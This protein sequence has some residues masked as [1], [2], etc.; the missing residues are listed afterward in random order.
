M[1]A[2]SKSAIKAFFETGDKPTQSQFSDLIDSYVDTL[3]VC[4]NISS[5]A[6]AGGTGLVNVISSAS[7]SLVSSGVV[8]LQLLQTTTTAAAQNVLAVGAVGRN[9]FQA[10]TTA[11]A[12]NQLGPGAFGATMFTTATT[13]AATNALGGGTVG[14]Q[15]F[16]TTTT[17]AAQNI[18]GSGL[19]LGTPVTA[20]GASVD[21]TSIPAGVKRIVVDFSGLSTNGTSNV[22]VQIGGSGGIEASSY[23]GAASII[24]SGGNSTNNF[25]TG[26]GVTLLESAATVFNGQIILNLQDSST[27]TWVSSTGGGLSSSAT[28]VVGGGSKSIATTLDRLRITMVNGT[29]TFDAGKI[30]IQYQI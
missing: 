1:T 15:I 13:A 26:F 30:N 23:L 22:M 19:T 17:A 3:S 29:D 27:N 14:V 16:Q 24:N 20:S 5:L 11:A 28:V 4:G 7:A 21:F 9:L 8:G 6:S 25:T 10:A 2:S 12:F 18:I